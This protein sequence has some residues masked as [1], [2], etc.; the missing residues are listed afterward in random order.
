MTTPIEVSLPAVRAFRMARQHLVSPS[1][2]GSMLEAV[3]AVHGIQSQVD[4]HA[5]F[6]VGQRVAKAGP[7]E[8]KR[9]LWQD[10]TLVKTWAMRG[11]LHWLPSDEE[12]LYASALS[13][14]RSARMFGWMAR[15]G[16]SRAK[17]DS[18]AELT[19]EA[20]DGRAMTRGE[21]AEAVIP[22]AG[23]WVAPYLL[24]SWGSGMGALCSMGLVVF[25]PPRGGSTTFVRRDQWLGDPPSLDPAGSRCELLRRYL[26]AFGPA[27]MQDFAY[28]LG[29]P[30]RDIADVCAAV[31][32]ELATVSVDGRPRWILAEDVEALA[33]SASGRMPVR[34][35][36][37]FDPLM[38]AHRDKSDHLDMRFHKRVYGVAAWVYPVV[39]VEGVARAT[40][41]Y[42]RTSSRLLVTVKPFTRTNQRVMKAVERE[43]RRLGAVVGLEGSVEAITQHIMAPLG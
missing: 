36:P 40:W 35:L 8:I 4:A 33:S 3:T 7:A 28:W 30:N 27:T 20:L 11:T 23:D 37:A 12:P 24:S 9:A 16:H 34:L 43:A 26:R 29:I 39:L 41:S 21:I 5:V 19:M 2:A 22:A 17:V 38:L 25:G 10:R 31:T 42:K 6:A 15:D 32:P 18:F 14:L 1:P 13:D